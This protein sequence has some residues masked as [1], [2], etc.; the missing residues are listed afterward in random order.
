MVSPHPH[1]FRQD[2]CPDWVTVVLSK[3]DDVFRN[4][5][6]KVRGKERILRRTSVDLA[7]VPRRIDE[8]L[9]FRLSFLEEPHIVGN[10][11][12]SFTSM[13]KY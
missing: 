12:Y 5:I 6:Y 11:R 13:L 9:E 2:Q 8:H 7:I 4:G 3:A 10:F 1:D